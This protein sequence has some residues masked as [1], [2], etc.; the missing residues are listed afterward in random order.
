[1]LIVGSDGRPEGA[2]YHTTEKNY[3][4]EVVQRVM[5]CGIEVFG[6]GIMDGS[7]EEFYPHWAVVKKAEELPRAVM[8]QLIQHLTVQGMRQN[9]DGYSIGSA[10]T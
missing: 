5:S 3:L 1:M 10:T 8:A 9:A 2:R 7:V 6:L 4:R